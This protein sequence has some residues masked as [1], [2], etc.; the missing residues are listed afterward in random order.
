MRRRRLTHAV[1][2]LFGPR[3]EIDDMPLFGIGPMALV[4]ASPARG[5]HV[6]S[7]CRADVVNPAR[8][9]PIDDE[10]WE[11]RLRCGAC[12]ATREV[13]IT[14]AVAARYDRDLDRGW[15]MIVRE[16]QR[17]DREE[18]AGWTERFTRALEDDLIDAGD[19]ARGD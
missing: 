1:R 7:E 8:A 19:F 16:V 6:C 5:L 18:M 14:N 13:V 15:S 9:E 17:L 12:G 3:L 10:H 11:V 2:W 4:A